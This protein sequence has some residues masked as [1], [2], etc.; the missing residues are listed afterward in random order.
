MTAVDALPRIVAFQ[1][2]LARR[3]AETVREFPGGFAVLDDRHPVSYEHNQLYVTGPVDAGGLVRLADRLLRRRRHRHVSVLDDGVGKA[4]APRLVAAGYTHEHTLVMT[5]DGDPTGDAAGVRVDRLPLE[6]LRQAVDHD[7]AETYPE[8]TDDM[9]AQLFERRFRT[10][11]ACDLSTHAV[12]AGGEVV[13][14][15]HLYVAGGEAQVESVTTLTRWRRRG[16]AKAVVLDA[17]SA[18][19]D[20]GCELVFLVADRE[21]WP[22]RFY[23][24]LGFATAGEQHGFVRAPA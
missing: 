17:V 23:Q 6:A 14:W 9:R 11:A 20:A 2:G 18:A 16:F 15:C 10:A 19:R 13:S 21:D 7:W 1:T 24:R 5:L 22:W 12:V 3:S 4:V 8:M